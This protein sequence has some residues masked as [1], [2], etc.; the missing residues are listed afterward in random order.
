MKPED[1]R[2]QFARSKGK[3][4]RKKP[5]NEESNCQINCVKW[6]RF[7]YPSYLI[8]AI[9]NGGARNKITGAIMKREGVVAGVADLCVLYGNGDHN[10]LYIEMKTKTGKQQPTQKAF[11]EHCVKQGYKYV[12]CNSFDSF[13]ETIEDYITTKQ[14]KAIQPAIRN[15][16]EKKY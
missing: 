7:V 6:F 8:F 9:P 5:S 10:G 2:K 14:A 13:K 4:P 3:Q 1:F 16:N 12:I 11:E 15:R